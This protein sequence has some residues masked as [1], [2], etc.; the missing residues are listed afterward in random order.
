MRFWKY[1]GLGNDFVLVENFDGSVSKD[2]STFVTY[3]TAASGSAP[4]GYSIW[5][6]APRPISPCG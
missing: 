5:R 2:P 4:T 1:H 3:V 6:T